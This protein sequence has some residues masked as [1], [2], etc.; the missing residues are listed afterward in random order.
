[1]KKHEAVYEFI[2]QY[3]PL[4]GILYFNSIEEFYQATGLIP[5]YGDNVQTEYT[6]GDAEKLYT[7]AIVQMKA[8]DTGTSDINLQA[9]QDAEAFADWIEQK[10][11]EHNFPIFPENCHISKIKSLQNMPNMAGTNEQGIAKYMMQFQIEYF[12]ERRK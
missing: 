10:N 11:E 9:M 8:F 6:S 7:F 5:V 4:D 12:E 3:P 1:M 2:K